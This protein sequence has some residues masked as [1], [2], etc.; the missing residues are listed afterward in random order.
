MQK[1]VALNKKDVFALKK[2]IKKSLIKKSTQAAVQEQRIMVVGITNVG[3][4]TLINT[5]TG[6]GKAKTGSQPGVTRGETMD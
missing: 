5:L 6:T 1:V 2:F 4:S 3:K